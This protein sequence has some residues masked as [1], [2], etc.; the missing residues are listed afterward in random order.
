[1]SQTVNVYQR[2]ERKQQFYHDFFLE[3]AGLFFRGRFVS[4]ENPHFARHKDG[5]IVRPGVRNNGA[6]AL[7]PRSV[8]CD[9]LL[10]D[11][12]QW[13]N[14]TTTFFIISIDVS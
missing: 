9:K 1:M 5:G 13:D 2:V 12:W 8:L 3:S 14:E 6:R 7:E 4:S 11:G 10:P